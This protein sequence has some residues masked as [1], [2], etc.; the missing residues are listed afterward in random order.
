[1][2]GGSFLDWR[3][4]RGTRVALIPRDGSPARVPLGVH[5]TWL[6]THE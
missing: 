5:G 1:M 2:E 3:P 4:E 6:P